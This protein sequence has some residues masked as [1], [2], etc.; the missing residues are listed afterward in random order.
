MQEEAQEGNVDGENKP[1][2]K[3]AEVPSSFKDGMAG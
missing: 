3:K 2:K 1:I